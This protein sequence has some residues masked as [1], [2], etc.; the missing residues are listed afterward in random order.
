M[1]REDPDRGAGGGGGQSRPQVSVVVATRGRPAL[2]RR[3]LEALVRQRLAGGRYEVLVV[4]DGPD[5]ATRRTVEAFAAAAGAPALRY[6]R[7]TAAPG[8]AGARNVGWRASTAPLIAF[9]DDDTVP[10]AGWLHH[11][12]A[13]MAGGAAAASGRVRVPL[14]GTPTDHARMTQGLE[15]AE[16]VTANAFVRRDV[17]ARI[18]GFDERFRRAWR[19]DSDLHFAIL[20]LGGEVVRAEQA[21]VLHPVRPVRWGVSLGQQANVVFDGLLYKKHRALFRQKVRRQPPWL[22]IAIVGLAA[23]AAAALAGG[24][25]RVAAGC[26]AGAL[27]GIGRFAAVRLRGTSHAPSHVGEMLCTSALIPF[28]ALGWR[29]V[30]AWRFKVLYP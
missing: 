30:G 7:N 28:L 26:A 14:E 9:T 6:L 11:G 27:A 13:A 4:D 22:Y 23:A 19:E 1:K 17:L 21:V 3:C 2:L 16:F 5:D 12:C 18:G 20:S 25:P 15:T 29:V 24:A 10:D 8:P